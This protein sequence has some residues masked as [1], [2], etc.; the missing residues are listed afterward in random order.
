M[1]SP[2]AVEFELARVWRGE[3]PLVSLALWPLSLV[4]GA[5]AVVNRALFILGLRKRIRLDVPVISIGNL[6]VGGAGKTP[7]TLEV[8]R[9]LQAVGRRVAVLSRGYGRR[10]ED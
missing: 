7:V 1:I 3:R 9:R 10:S 4:Y 8:A 5:A 2:A 6:V